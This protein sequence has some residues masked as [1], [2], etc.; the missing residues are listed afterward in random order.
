MLPNK[1]LQH[2]GRLVRAGG[3]FSF[4]GGAESGEVGDLGSTDDLISLLIE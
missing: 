2:L 3:D 1:W 4:S